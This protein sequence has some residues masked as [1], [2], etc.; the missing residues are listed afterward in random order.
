MGAVAESHSRKEPSEPETAGSTAWC[1]ITAEEVE[2]Q[3]QTSKLS[4]LTDS[5]VATRLS[6]HGANTIAD[7]QQ[8]TW[9]AVLGRQ[10][11]DVLIWILIGAAAISATIGEVTDAITILAIVVLN[12]ILGF[13]QE[14]KA[15]RALQALR[16]MLSPTCRVLRNGAIVVVNAEQL[17]PGD[18]IQLETGDR[19]PADLRMLEATNL[20]VDESA[21]TGE[22]GSVGKETGA[23]PADTVLAKQSSMV[24]MGTAVTNGRGLGAVVATGST[25][26]FGRIA[27]LTSEIV[28]DRTPLQRKL[29]TL[30]RQ[31][32]VWAIGVSVLVVIAG[33]IS[34]K[35][36]VEMLMTGISLAVAVVPEG[37][38]AVV[39]ITLAL[40]IRAMVRRKALLRRLQAAEALGSATV[41]CTDKTGTLTQNQMTVQQI[42][43]PSVGRN[44]RIGTAG[45]AASS[46]DRRESNGLAS[47]NDDSRCSGELGLDPAYG[48]LIDV[49]GVGYDPA[50]HFESNGE[51]VD[52]RSHESLLALLE[53]GLRCNHAQVTRDDDGW[54]ESGEPTEAALVVAAYK[55]WLDPGATDDHLKEFSFSSDRKRMSVVDP[56][57]GCQIAHVKGAPEVILQRC[58]SIGAGDAAQGMSAAAR[59][60]VRDVCN[61]MADRG[62]RT[63]AIARHALPQ[64]APL[65]EDI[66]EQELT[67]LGIVGIIDPP[68]P[69]V[70]EAVRRAKSAG[71]KLVM[72][73]GDASRTALAIAK[74]IG[75]DVDQSV[76]G[77]QLSTMSDEL[78]RDALNNSAVFARTTPEHKLRI[79]KLLQQDGHVVG[80]TG[81]GVNDAP[82]LKKADIGIAMGLRGTD[83]AKGAADIVLTNDNFSSII[84]AVEEGRRQYDNIQKFVRYMLSSNTGE[85]VAIF[86]N[87]LIGGPL[88]LLPVQILWMN[89]ITDSLIALALGLENAET[90]IMERPPRD[91]AEPILNRRAIGMIA[92]LGFYVG[93]ATLWIFHHVLTDSDS[94]TVALAQTMAFH[95]I[96]VIE[97]F[98]VMNFRTLRVPVMRVGLF[99]NRWMLIAIAVTAC[100]QLCAL[101]VPL[102]QRALHTVPLG[103]QDWGLIVIVS[104]PV[105]AVCEV[106]KWWQQ[107][108]RR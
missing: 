27:S 74:R 106:F 29:G 77:T 43:L 93:L 98:N 13:V 24:W 56:G 48:Q 1:A 91:P 60:Q 50:G 58:T 80:M 67:L 78:L 15:E 89:L 18:V 87:I 96:I 92:G 88:I 90:D 19:I 84:N 73:T 69:E 35:A 33:L 5:E 44:E 63:L 23:V 30:G 17:V 68:R 61:E 25:T 38:P 101:Y 8:T 32:G 59:L 97:W 47:Q 34:G 11:V 62:L 39:T 22:S 102:L 37:L 108:T 53:S 103:W 85:A 100:V 26:Q 83:V 82:A 66:V 54:H 45:A 46:L 4:G 51:V 2:Q 107:R 57:E 95:G 21:L 41:I 49:T 14:W 7:T 16:Q 79:V 42:W 64:N 10:F 36:I 6:H 31:L 70:P 75:M 55:A 40:G 52:Y 99:S 86:F 65:T 9:L 3:L 104:L 28:T 12:G 71:I 81:D 72:I 76:E 94:A 20:R 105:F